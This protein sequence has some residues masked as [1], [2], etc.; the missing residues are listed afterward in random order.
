MSEENNIVGFEITKPTHFN[1]VRNDGTEV[2]KIEMETGIIILNEEIPQDELVVTIFNMI[3][4]LRM[5]YGT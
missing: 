3:N 4:Q 1:F 2:F 5:S